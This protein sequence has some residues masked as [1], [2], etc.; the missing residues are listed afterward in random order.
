MRTAK[1]V[2]ARLLPGKSNQDRV[3]N[4]PLEGDHRRPRAF[5]TSVYVMPHCESPGLRPLCLYEARR[6]SQIADPCRKPPSGHGNGPAARRRR[7]GYKRPPR[8][9]EAFTAKSAA[10]GGRGCRVRSRCR[11]P[12][13][14]RGRSDRASVQSL[15]GARSRVASP[16]F[17]QLPGS[18]PY[19]R[20]KRRPMTARPVLSPTRSRARALEMPRPF[21][22]GR[23]LE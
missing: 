2:S 9:A 18:S 12:G 19:G 4:P 14:L 8:P 23:V 7:A 1:A 6:R 10:A 21:P 15:A 3:R 13:P 22:N 5:L 16:Q 20:R 11:R 17:L